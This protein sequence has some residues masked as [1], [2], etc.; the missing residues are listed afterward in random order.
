MLKVPD[1]VNAED[2]V[3]AWL[4]TLSSHCYTKSSF[5]PGEKVAV[6][7]LGTLGMGCVALGQLFGANVIGIANSE[8]RADM[9]KSNGADAAFLSADPDLKQKILDHTHGEGVDLVIL[10]ANP[11]PAH[12]IACEIVRNN[13]RVGIV[14]LTG[15][16][17]PPPDFNPLDMSLFY[18]KGISLV[19]ISGQE[20]ELFPSTS[21]LPWESGY[22]LVTG[23]KTGRFVMEL[24]AKGRL[25][26]SKIITHRLHWKHIPDAYELI[27]QR[28]KEI[29]GCVFQW[30][31][32]YSAYNSRL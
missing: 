29:L 8:I 21:S 7:G 30:D 19:A 13:G 2:A 26:P 6:V 16:G 23:S 5:R 20:A 4:W 12:K 10:T 3:W 17:E 14:A 18:A 25:K 11:F 32:S 24:I 9:A 15:R 22:P 1:H 31:E 28:S 27:Y